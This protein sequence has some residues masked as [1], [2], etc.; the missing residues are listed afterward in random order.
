MGSTEKLSYEKWCYLDSNPL[1]LTH[2]LKM[3][4]YHLVTMWATRIAGEGL[5]EVWHNW[6][7]PEK[8]DQPAQ[9][10][11]SFFAI[12][13]NFEFFVEQDPEEG[14]QELALRCIKE[15]CGRRSI[16]NSSRV[17]GT[18]LRSKAQPTTSEVAIQ[19]EIQKA[20]SRPNFNSENPRECKF[21][22]HTVISSFNS[23]MYTNTKYIIY[24]S[25]RNST[26]V[27]QT[28][29]KDRNKHN[30]FKLLCQ[31]C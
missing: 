18:V 14:Q 11:G 9:H 5:S 10:V 12:F 4:W 22:W 7:Q 31:S 29:L 24:L 8:L 16:V 15:E 19:L 28:L 20:E 1:N 21:H 3:T 6:D 27:I 13:P 23:H 26:N 17:E 2:S 25:T 30:K